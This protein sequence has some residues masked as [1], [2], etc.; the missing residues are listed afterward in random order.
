MI[1]PFTLLTL[2]VHYSVS[3]S[4]EIS[5]DVIVLEGKSI[6]ITLKTKSFFI[7]KWHLFL[8]FN[9]SFATNNREVAS[10]ILTRVTKNVA[11]LVKKYLVPIW[12]KIL[13]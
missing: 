10:S 4:L 12:A 9:K 7:E 1:L 13:S 6:K 8:L 2:L 5:D 3:L 11:T